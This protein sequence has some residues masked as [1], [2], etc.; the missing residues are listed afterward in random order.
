MLQIG[1][2]IFSVYFCLINDFSCDQYYFFV[3]IYQFPVI[4]VWK[5][6]LDN[7]NY[8]NKNQMF[9]NPE[10]CPYMTMTIYYL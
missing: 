3:E 5:N 8:N 10:H 7:S 6:Y 9:T 2:K 1:E 4:F